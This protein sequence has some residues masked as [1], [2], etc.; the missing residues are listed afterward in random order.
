MN[1]AQQKLQIIGLITKLDNIKDIIKGEKFDIA[2]IIIKEFENMSFYSLSVDD[3][4]EV[5]Q[6]YFEVNK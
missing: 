4:L 3:F 1:L 6:R 2:E 5:G